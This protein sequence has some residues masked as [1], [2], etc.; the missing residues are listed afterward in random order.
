MSGLFSSVRGLSY[1]ISGSCVLFQNSG[2]A[3]V[4]G[5]RSLD[6]GR[7]GIRFFTISNEVPY[8]LSY[9]VF[10]ILRVAGIGFKP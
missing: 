9:Q 2:F 1:E 4:Y 3:L 7:D 5:W 10:S 6:N 8:V